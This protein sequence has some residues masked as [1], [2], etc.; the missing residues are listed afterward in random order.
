[1]LF[2]FTLDKL[3]PHGPGHS[4]GLGVSLHPCHAGG[5]PGALDVTSS[6]GKYHNLE[7]FND[8]SSLDEG[9]L[10]VGLCG[11]DPLCLDLD[12]DAPLGEGEGLLVHTACHLVLVDPLEDAG[13]HLRHEALVANIPF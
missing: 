8:Q 5:S 13:A 9:S 11:L 2:V 7:N 12:G 1:M 6:P 10:L 4:Q 3:L